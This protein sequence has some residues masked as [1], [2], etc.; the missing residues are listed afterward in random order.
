[1]FVITADQVASRRNPDAVG[2]IVTELTQRFGDALPLPPER[3][4]GDEFQLIVTTGSD[5]LD[6]MLLLTRAGRWSVGLG[7][8]N[9]QAPLPTSIRETTGDAFVGARAAVDRAKKKNTR[10]AIEA[11]GF[12]DEA[13]RVEAIVDLLLATRLRRSPEGWELFDLLQSGLTQAASAARLGISP[14]AASLRAQAADLRIEAAV[15]DAV[16]SLLSELD[17]LTAGH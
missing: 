12:E 17:G 11:I 5:A 13:A 14:Q 4:A 16:G 8:G 3:T 6:A 2:Q 9:V 1:M 7:V 10:C 15:T